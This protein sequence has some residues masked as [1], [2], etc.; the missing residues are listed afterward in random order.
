MKKNFTDNSGQKGLHDAEA[1]L[2]DL[3]GTLYLGD[4]LIDGAVE[5]LGFLRQQGKRI[6]FLTN[7]S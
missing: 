4:R 5:T 3:D 7:N 1:F 6:V 2:F